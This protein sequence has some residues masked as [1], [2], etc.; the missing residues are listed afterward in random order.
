MNQADR[1][2]QDCVDGTSFDMVIKKV[3]DVT[4]E[5][6]K[7][8][9]MVLEDRE[10]DCAAIAATLTT[11]LDKQCKLSGFLSMPWCV[12]IP[13]NKVFKWSANMQFWDQDRYTEKTEAMDDA[14]SSCEDGLGFAKVIDHFNE[15]TEKFAQ[16]IICQLI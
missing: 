13:P 9:S 14:L 15:Y 3:E 11:E 12:G 2:Y 8:A 5:L 6:T 4:E 16:I 10:K 7:H 1:E